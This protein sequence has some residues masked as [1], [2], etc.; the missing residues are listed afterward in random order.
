MNQLKLF[1]ALVISFFIIFSTQVESK[2]CP[3]TIHI[4]GKRDFKTLPSEV[5]QECITEFEK[6]Y[7]DAWA[8]FENTTLDRIE[9][10][11]YLQRVFAA[12]YVLN[13]KEAIAKHDKLIAHLS[14]IN[15]N[16]FFKI[17][18]GSD[19]SENSNLTIKDIKNSDEYPVFSLILSIYNDELFIYD[20]LESSYFKMIP[21]DMRHALLQPILADQVNRDQLDP[22]LLRIYTQLESPDEDYVLMHDPVVT[23]NGMVFAL[24]GKQYELSREIYENFEKTYFSLD[25]NFDTLVSWGWDILILNKIA[26]DSAL[27]IQSDNEIVSNRNAL[28]K[29]IQNSYK[30]WKWS[31]DEET[32]QIEAS[33]S[34]TLIKSDMFLNLYDNGSCELALEVF[35]DVYDAYFEEL[36]LVEAGGKGRNLKR[37]Y[38]FFDDDDPFFEPVEA[39]LC[40]IELGRDDDAEKFLDLSAR[41]LS[42]MSG[43]ITPVKIGLFESTKLI[44]ELQNTSLEKSISA[45]NGLLKSYTKESLFEVNASAS[46]LDDL[47]NNVFFIYN[48][49]ITSGAEEESLLDPMLAYNLKFQ[50]TEHAVLKDLFLSYSSENLSQ[51]QFLF[52]ELN[53]KLEKLESELLSSFNPDTLQEIKDLS[54]KKNSL[55]ESI[56]ANNITIKSLSNP[57]YPS[58][59]QLKEKSLNK[60]III[61]NMGSKDSFVALIQDGDF[62]LYDLDINKL[63]YGIHLDKINESIDKKISKDSLEYSFESAFAIYSSMFSDVLSQVSI[64]QSIII[65]GSDLSGLPLWALPRNKPLGKDYVSNFLNANWLINDYSFAFFFPISPSAPLKKAYKNSFIGFG[66]PQLNKE[67]NLPSLPSAE[68]EMIQL[69][70]YS[71]AS[72]DSI[73][74]KQSATK[75]SFLTKLTEPTQRFALGTHSVAFDPPNK[76]FQPSLLFSGE[77]SIIT[78]ADIVNIKI[79]SE[80]ILLTACN[81]IKDTNDHNFTLLP[82]SFL[83]AGSDSVLFSNWNIE[84]ISSSKISK[85]IFKNLWLNDDLSI[86]ESLRMSVKESLKNADSIVS[87][88]PKFWA[89]MSVAYGNI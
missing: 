45:Y 59:K 88:H 9:E 31:D 38:S 29:A 79:S 32:K 19:F 2:I 16:I 65:Y 11:E 13:S 85:G 35:E 68:D 8:F 6:N 58:L 37:S 4:D 63:H 57:I 27:E 17:F 42:H 54:Y 34:I 3:N 66:N 44:Y 52:L 86:E 46:Y 84:S 77:D 30:K 62:R 12:I 89:G 75:E 48:F 60:A 53:K 5:Y 83:V 22:N 67:F 28:I 87:M 39:A 15:P 40:A 21:H 49:L 50:V 78:A 18:I 64:D 7:G 25:K 70:L 33:R 74:L 36:I 20:A 76:I 73:F 43:Y 55:L 61:P 72:Q 80:L 14:P 47:T 56:Y 82:R 26:T 71:G 69:A 10:S 1:T 24:N 51:D 81:T 41:S 23:A